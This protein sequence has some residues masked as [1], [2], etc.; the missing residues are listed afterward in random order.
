MT[1]FVL[2]GVY[3]AIVTPFTKDEKIDFDALTELIQFIENDVDGI[4]V[5]GTTGEFDYLSIEEKRRLYERC[6][7]TLSSKRKVIAGTGAP[8]TRNVIEIVKYA[9]D[10]GVDACL[11]ASPYYLTPK[12]KGMYEH[13]YRISRETDLPIILYNI[14]QCTRVYISRRVIEDLAEIDNICG[15]KDSS[16]NL[17]YI[18]EILEKVGNKMNVV[19]GYDEIVLP[20][21]IAGCSG[22]ILASAQVFPD[23]WKEIYRLVKNNELEKAQKLQFKIQKLARMFCRYG[24][25]VPVKYALRVMGISVGRCRK[26]LMEGGVIL[27]EDR[28]EIKLEL[29]RIGKIQ[30][31]KTFFKSEYKPLKKRFDVFGITE[32]DIEKYKLLV[33]D[34]DAG[35]DIN[36]VHVDVIYG[37][38]KSLLGKV[39]AKELTYPRQGY[40]ALPAILEPNLSVRPSTL[41]VPMCEIKNLRQANMFYG[42]AQNGIAKSIVDS[43]SMNLI[44]HNI[45]ETYIG[46]AKVQIDPNALSRD[47]IHKNVYS[48]MSIALKQSFG[49]GDTLYE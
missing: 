16:G 8:S 25:A 17:P 21:L 10:I 34:G 49:R 22:M 3:A 48:A 24:G 44:P 14:P 20:A 1:K 36:R 30:T 29:E 35:T 2:E 7:E 9:E 23:I 40:E 47:I 38:K 41:I 13:F 27:S 6:V 11:I 42:P 12:D 39:F 33:G 43:I 19:I 31:K 15:L 5:C 18:M 37:N 32:T 46:L 4:V 26:P 28:E 45:V